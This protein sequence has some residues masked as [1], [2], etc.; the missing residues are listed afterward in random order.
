[1]STTAN[2]DHDPVPC[3][4]SNAVYDN[5]NVN[6][7]LEKINGLDDRYPKNKFNNFNDLNK[8]IDSDYIPLL[9]NSGP[10]YIIQFFCQSKNFVSSL[11]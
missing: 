1:M 5:V 11:G 4:R 7:M 8:Y 3:L 2:A 10:V 6:A 9:E